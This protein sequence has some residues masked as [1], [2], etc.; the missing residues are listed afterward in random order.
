MGYS[1]QPRWVTLLLKALE[2]VLATEGV[3]LPQ[4]AVGEAAALL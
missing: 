2:T 1:S 4:G 3:R